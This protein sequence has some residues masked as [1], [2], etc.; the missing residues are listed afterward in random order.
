MSFRFHVLG[1]IRWN[2]D[3]GLFYQYGLSGSR[4]QTIFNSVINDLGQ[5]VPRV[6][7]SKPD[8]FNS[9]GHFY[10]FIPTQ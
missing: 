10:P 1:P 4:D 7:K 6:V 9:K 2:I 8:Y 3:A 5:L